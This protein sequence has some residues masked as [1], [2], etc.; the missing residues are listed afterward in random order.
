MKKVLLIAGIM[1]LLTGC[2]NTTNN[3]TLDATTDYEIDT[4]TQY[5]GQ[6]VTI[7]NVIIF[8]SYGTMELAS[9][10]NN[11]TFIKYSCDNLSD[12]DIKSFEG[13]KVTIRGE[14]DN[15]TEYI[16]NM[17]NCTIKH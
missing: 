14:I 8:N 10:P 15:T 3:N 4:Y 9:N 1:L 5:I 6:T 11:P 16:V 7:T 2:G 12:S 13:Y 17:K